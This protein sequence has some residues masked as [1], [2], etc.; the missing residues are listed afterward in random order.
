MDT[1]L[2]EEDMKGAQVDLNLS[3]KRIKELRV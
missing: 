3:P 1:G 2:T